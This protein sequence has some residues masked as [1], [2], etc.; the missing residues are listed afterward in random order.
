MDCS[1]AQGNQGCNGGLMDSAFQY[2]IANG[3]IG[4]EASYPYKAADGTCQKVT[5]ESTPPPS[6]CTS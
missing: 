2:I 1:G 4:S 3:G 5:C 6:I